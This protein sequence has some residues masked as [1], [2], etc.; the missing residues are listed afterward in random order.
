MLNILIDFIPVLLFFIAFKW[1][2]IYQATVVGIVATGAQVIFTRLWKKKFDKQQVF[3]FF[4]FLFFGGLTLYFHNPIFVKWK[5]SI[6]FWILGLVFILSQLIGNKPLSQRMLE[7]L[8]EE[9][10]AIPAIVWKRLNLGWA[11]F[12]ILLGTLNI[13]IAYHYSTE[14]WVNFK[15]YGILGLFFL[16]GFLQSLYISRYMQAK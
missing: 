2:G 8:I 16:F 3:T 12:F 1:W 6:I 11:T 7:H 15:F 13:F 9:K 14:T 4:V 5:P 10:A